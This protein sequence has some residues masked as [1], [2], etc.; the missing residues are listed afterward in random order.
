[1]APDT[2]STPGIIEIPAV[3]DYECHHGDLLVE[4][5]DPN[6]PVEASEDMITG[7]T[8]VKPLEQS[9]YTAS[10]YGLEAKWRVEL[11]SD[12]K[13]VEDTV[14]WEVREDGSIAVTWISMVSGSYVLKYKDLE[15]TVIV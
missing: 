12:N 14:E 15:K 1:M 6:P 5:V 10:N 9:I 13:D 3:E 11:S 2:I 4:V 8:F 7:E